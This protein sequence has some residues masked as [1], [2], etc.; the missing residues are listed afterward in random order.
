MMTGEYFPRNKV[1]Y[2]PTPAGLPSAQELM[3]IG[4]LLKCGGDYEVVWK[5]KWHL[6]LPLAGDN[7]W[8]EKD[9]TNVQE[10]Y[11]IYQWNPPDA[12]NAAFPQATFPDGTIFNGLL[13]LGG[14][15]A[16][17]DQRFLYGGATGWGQGAIEYIKQKKGSNKP[18]CLFISLV[19]PHDVWTYPLGWEE[20][21][22]KRDEFANLGIQ[23]PSN[24][25]DDLTT[26]PSIQLKAREAYQSKVPLQNKAQEI[27]YVNFY[28]YLHKVVDAHVMKILDALEEAGVIENTIIIR[29]ADHGELGLSHGMRQ[30]S[31]TAY[32]E[33]IHIPLVISNPTLFPKSQETDAFYC[34]LDLMPTI[35]D[36]LEIPNFQQYG[37]GV[38]LAP[39][40]KGEKLSVQ[41]SILF[42]FDDHFVLPENTPGGHIRA[43]RE[44][45]WLYAVYY[46]TDGTGF[47]YEMYNLKQDPEQRQN[48]LFKS[49]AQE[50]ASEAYRLHNLLKQKIDAAE[51]LPPNF[52]WPTPSF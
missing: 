27:E 18:F 49:I 12:G 31:F 29:T 17:N 41:E 46:S 45:D 7:N 26:K 34:H 8:S 44:G 52:P 25:D 33:M 19:N 3:D 9:I 37:K 14:G 48:L 51:A 21:G 43:L 40:L 42:N 28:A 35:A 50:N 11:N 10:R 2:T 15:N 32:E 6:N 16:N 36:L 20:A 4:R 1:Q 5:G 30:K 24:F 22:Y 13:T 39:V 23:L 47:E 38:S